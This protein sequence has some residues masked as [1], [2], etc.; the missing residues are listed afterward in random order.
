MEQTLL[1]RL[2]QHQARNLRRKAMRKDASERPAQRMAHHKIWR[3]DSRACERRMQLVGDVNR[4]VR[5]GAG[6]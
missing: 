2:D 6:R 4:I 3:L 5:A 1:G